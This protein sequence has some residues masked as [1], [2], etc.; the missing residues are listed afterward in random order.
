M[1][2]FH[3]SFGHLWE[4][5]EGRNPSLEGWALI[6]LLS[7]CCIEQLREIFF[8]SS[9][10]GVKQACRDTEANKYTAVNFWVITILGTF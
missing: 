10:G 3:K 4:G 8:L 7:P 2:F 5:M 6:V 9:G 1:V